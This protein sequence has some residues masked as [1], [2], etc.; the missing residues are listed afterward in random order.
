MQYKKSQT[1]HSWKRPLQ[2]GS[3]A[4]V[5]Y[6][7]P[8]HQFPMP[9]SG[10]QRVGIQGLQEE[11]KRRPMLPPC[12]RPPTTNP[13]RHRRLIY[14]SCSSLAM[15]IEGN[16]KTFHDL[17]IHRSLPY[18]GSSK[19][20]C[21]YFED[22][23]I[24]NGIP[25][26]ILRERRHGVNHSFGSHDAGKDGLKGDIVLFLSGFRSEKA[27]LILTCNNSHLGTDAL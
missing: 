7:T 23:L 24:H 1:W 4:K 26:E 12:F 19:G 16:K 3:G 17:Y 9:S 11:R 22:Y 15:K 18:N 14:V 27:R 21:R 13:A 8:H 2:H 5:E 25:T 20:A 6:T 10:L